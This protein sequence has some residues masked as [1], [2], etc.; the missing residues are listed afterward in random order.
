MG[1]EFS[2]K[3]IRFACKSCA[4][5]KAREGTRGRGFLYSA[6]ECKLGAR[7]GHGVKLDLLLGKKNFL[8]KFGC[9]GELY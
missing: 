1:V 2:I 8:R 9:L 4:K 3:N 6:K 7:Y 5:N